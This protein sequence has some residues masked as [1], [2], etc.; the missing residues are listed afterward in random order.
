M[1]PIDTENFQAFPGSSEGGDSRADPKSGLAFAW[2]TILALGADETLPEVL[3]AWAVAF[4]NHLGVIFARIWT[5]SSTGRGFDLQANAGLNTRIEGKYAQIPV[6]GLVEHVASECQPYA[7]DDLVNDPWLGDPEWAIQK[8][9]IAFAGYPL[10][11]RGKLVGVSTVF[12]KQPISGLATQMLATTA[13]IIARTIARNHSEAELG[14]KSRELEVK[15]A[16]LMAASQRSQLV[17]ESVPNGILVVDEAGI[18]TL[19]NAQAEKMFGFQ[20]EEL[21]GQPVEILLPTS[22]R[23]SHPDKRGSFFANPQARAMGAGRDLFAVRKDG[24][25]FPVEIGLNPIQTDGKTSVLCS[26][27]DITWRKKYESALEETARELKTRN[28]ELI[29]AGQRYQ[30]VIESAPNG[31]LVVDQAGV[32]TLANAHAEKMFGFQREELIGHPVEK[33]LPAS[34]RLSHPSKRGSFF[35][36]PQAR[37]MGAG[38]DLSAVRKDGS[39]FPVEIGLNPIQ[40]D[41]DISVL[42]SI[43]DITERRRAES[44]I[45]E[46]T[47]LKSEFLANMSHEI[48]TPMNVLVGM[49]GLLL[50]TDLT[51]DQRDQ[52]E[53][54]RKGAESL[55]VVI[56]DSLDF[57]KMEA[58]KLEIDRADFAVDT[59][60]EDVSS[61][62]SQQSGRKGLELT[63]FVAPDVPSYLYGD[64]GRVRQVLT[65]LVAN[66]VKFTEQGEV[67]VRVLMA[68]Q[69]EN[70]TTLRFEVQDTGIGILAEVQRRLFQAFTQADGSTT[71]RY[72][73]TGLGLAICKR[74]VEMMG[75]SIGIDSDFGKGSTFWFQIPFE[76][77]RE[78]RAADTE[79]APNFAGVRVLVVDDNETNRAILKQQLESWDMKPELAANAL[80]AVTI[81]RE[82]AISGCP[83]GLVVLDY[84]MPGMNGI[85][86]AR[87]VRADSNIASTPLMMLTSYSERR[88]AEAARDVG[89]SIYLTKPARRHQLHRAIAAIL[90]QSSEAAGNSLPARAAALRKG[91]KLL[92][93]EDNVDNQKLTTRL[94]R[95]YGYDCDVAANGNQALAIISKCDY[96][97]VL[98]D[99][100]M[101]EMDGFQATAAIREREGKSRRTPIVA[102][103]AHALPGDRERCLR[104]GMDDYIPK[105]VN[106]GLLLRTIER[107]VPILDEPV[108]APASQT[109]T[110]IKKIEPSAMP[111]DGGDRIRISA[112][113]GL[114]DLIPGYLSN[115]RKN[116]LV[117]GDAVAKADL[118]TARS[119]GHGMKGCGRGYGFEAISEIGRNIEHAAAVYDTSGVSTQI[120]LL[121]DF[122]SRLDVIYMS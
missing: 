68:G 31:I 44:R 78:V 19:I 39:E 98:M 10:V 12:S 118:D 61:F 122:L 28:V 48:R 46:A 76:R 57:S 29:A 106:E 35:G 54:I 8:D 38:R 82:S 88:E 14:E 24:S 69:S 92:L 53:T 37:A 84:G 97:L 22:M 75:G 17:I 70:V 81:I 119:I 93:V 96:P 27:V 15:H 20:R 34:M 109:P 5:I 80:Q 58:G 13:G 100:Q 43:V 103:T 120:V 41:G 16:E 26:I 3:Q 63:C 50:E 108:S 87:I 117:L 52:A 6:G 101:P 114:E 36:D 74:L 107:W 23:P 59:V 121:E 64:G 95:K 7:T 47:R 83:L 111:T 67:N 62:L 105:P 1:R 73:G 32:I 91:P 104:A 77:P 102:M 110:S 115:C 65:N 4:V 45:L 90:K 55:L 51:P 25:E 99:C 42:C 18:I 86:V 71:R 89:I 2:D 112:K 33:L 72:G 9:L 21:I 113:A 49:S 40:T 30:M 66:A 60:V 85:D 11:C 56:N 116:I 94:L 79:F